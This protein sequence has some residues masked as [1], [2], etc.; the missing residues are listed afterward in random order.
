[1][2][3]VHIKKN[4]YLFILFSIIKFIYIVSHSLST[5]N[6]FLHIYYTNVHIQ[7]YMFS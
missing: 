6:N 7:G 5:V 4:K 1:M 2:L 3:F